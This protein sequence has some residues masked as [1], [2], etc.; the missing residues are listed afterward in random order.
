M[1][2]GTSGDNHVEYDKKPKPTVWARKSPDDWLF[3][4]F[5]NKNKVEN[6]WDLLLVLD[7]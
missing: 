6:E 4:F 1:T 7:G 3:L 2:D 5:Y